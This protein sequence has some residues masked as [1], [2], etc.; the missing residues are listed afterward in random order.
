MFFLGGKELN[1]NLYIA[2]SLIL[3]IIAFSIYYIYYMEILHSPSGSLLS[4]N[5]VEVNGIS[6]IQTYYDC[7][8][9]SST[10]QSYG[11]KRVC[12]AI[13]NATQQSGEL[14][15]YFM[16]NTYTFENISEANKFILDLKSDLNTTPWYTEHFNVTTGNITYTSV[17]YPNYKATSQ[18]ALVLA[19]YAQKGNSVISVSTGIFTNCNVTITKSAVNQIL[20][21]SIKNMQ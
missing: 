4:K 8:P 5:K 2:A 20:T 18:G 10:M 3:L 21:E 17:Y 13:L 14:P 12:T 6:Y 7:I 15:N 16:I 19:A 1:R 11:Y 9:I